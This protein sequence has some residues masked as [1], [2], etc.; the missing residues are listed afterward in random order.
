[1]GVNNSKTIKPLNSRF[2][3][4][5]S[6]KEYQVS[7]PSGINKDLLN[8]NTIL[9][10]RIQ[11][12]EASVAELKLIN[13]GLRE[14]EEKYRML[15]A[16]C[17]SQ[18]I[19]DSKWAE[20]EKQN[21]EKE[22]HVAKMEAI[23]TFARDIANDFNNL[24]MGIQGVAAL[25]LLD[26][27][28]SHPHYENLR[29]IEEQVQRGVAL[30]DQLLGFAIEDKYEVTPTDMNDLIQK[31]SSIFGRTRKNITIERKCA[32]DLWPARVDR[33]QIEQVFQNLYANARQAMPGGGEICLETENIILNEKQA[34]SYD[35][36]PGK[37]VK[38][39]VTD[40]GAGMDEKTKARIF[41]PFFTTKRMGRGTGLGLATVYGIIK[42][43]E[44]I[45]NVYSEPGQGTMFIICLP[46][47]DLEMA[48]EKIDTETGI[49]ATG[50]ETILLVDD[51]EQIR[52][53][54]KEMLKSM[55]Y[56]VY[57]AA[58]GPEAIA[59]YLQK[60]DEIALVVLDLIMPG[61]SGEE[62][63]DRLKEINSN[64]NVLISSGDRLNDSVREILDRGCKGF[65]QK[66]FSFSRFS[67][68][69]REMLD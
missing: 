32:K 54:G 62:T 67:C 58:G 36:K 34:L 43:H 39:T 40:T 25:S 3:T 17:S 57:V 37:Y 69:I 4:L 31:T 51:E 64:V 41:E 61:M 13:D 11:E 27:E 52:E 49:I 9:K 8:E 50:T 68:K 35:V 53:V 26:F 45:I 19:T 16:L 30:T 5:I 7:E 33:G 20:D 14:S 22:L 2:P 18:D 15:S 44:G 55:G 47:S 63:L 66:P 56:Y 60:K 6:K 46:A 10:Q 1:M 12:L 48:I 29:R 24:L 59:L 28:P 65:L 21:L 23:G 38:I 42:G